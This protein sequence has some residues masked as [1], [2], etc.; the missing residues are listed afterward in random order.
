MGELISEH[1]ILVSKAQSKILLVLANAD[2]QDQINTVAQGC[3]LGLD[4]TRVCVLNT[5][6]YLCFMLVY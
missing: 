6:V 1:I 4:E 2:K 3:V 5:E